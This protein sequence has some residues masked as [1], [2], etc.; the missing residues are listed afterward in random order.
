MQQIV[1]QWLWAAPYQS[2]S[3]ETCLC[4]RSTVW[5]RHKAVWA[6]QPVLSEVTTL[7]WVQPIPLRLIGAIRKQLSVWCRTKCML[8]PSNPKQFY[9]ARLS[10]LLHFSQALFEVMFFFVQSVHNIKPAN[11]SIERTW[12][13][14]L[15]FASANDDC[16]TTALGKHVWATSE[17]TQ[18][19]SPHPDSNS[20]RESEHTQAHCRLTHRG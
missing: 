1:P 19:S 11:T 10:K 5:R 16:F 7:A 20:W 13:C 12:T 18:S 8:Y 4:G 14:L 9:L 3:D 2:S 17:I 15:S 6:M